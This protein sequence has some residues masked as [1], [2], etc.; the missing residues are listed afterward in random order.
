MR[1]A[2]TR[3][4]DIGRAAPGRNSDPPLKPHYISR[5]CAEQKEGLPKTGRPRLVLVGA[6]SAA[7]VSL[8]RRSP[9]WLLRR[10]GRSPV[11]RDRAKR[12]QCQSTR[13]CGG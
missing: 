9:Q 3:A 8:S 5:L 12:I 1:G 2:S 13:I 10:R 11:R 7:A 4:T 6:S